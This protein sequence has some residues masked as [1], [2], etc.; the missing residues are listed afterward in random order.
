MLS[1]TFL[2]SNSP[3]K[4]VGRGAIDHHMVIICMMHMCAL[5]ADRWVI[6]MAN[7][8][9]RRHFMRSTAMC[10]AAVLT[11]R[12]TSQSP[13]DPVSI[14]RANGASAKI[15]VQSL[16]GGISILAGSGGNVAVLCT[17]AAK[18]LVDSGLAT[19]RAQMKAAIDALGA[20]PLGQLINT[21]WHFDHTD[22]NEWMHGAGAVI[23][24]HENTKQ[25]LAT[26]QR[27]EF[28]GATF[29]PSPALALPTSVFSQERRLTVGNQR[30]LLQ[31]Y[32]PAHTDSDISV[33]FEDA[34]ILHCGD[35]FFN[36][37]YPFIDYSS[38][39]SIDG[40]IKAAEANLR[41]ADSESILIPGH[42]PTGNKADLQRFRDMLVGVR[43]EVA[44]QKLQ[45][46]T[47]AEVLSSEP[48]KKYDDRFKGVFIPSAAFVQLVF[49]GV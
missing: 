19:S 44:R 35:T 33:R 9:D 5:L 13:P 31:H 32:D 46:K 1:P 23:T 25:R 29:P 20:A 7:W 11:R 40:M 16:R 27:I 47:I 36:G 30:L 17:P 28:F 21:H 6:P 4:I 38:G 37:I 39:G 3:C 48:T 22:G 43:A 10:G 41:T 26:T 14:A 49:Q 18:V 2:I 45:G 15:A 8:I 34:N 24:A 42:G 12:M